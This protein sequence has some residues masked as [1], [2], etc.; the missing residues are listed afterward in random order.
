MSGRKSKQKGKR[1]EREVA[2]M[3]RAIFPEAKRGIQ[4]RGGGAE[5]ADVEIPAFHIEVKLQAKPNIRAA[6]RQA[7]AEAAPGKHPVAFT[8]ADRDDWVVSMR[9]EDWLELV[10]QWWAETGGRAA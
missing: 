4:S 8:R 5:I 2:T 9:G 7:V 1:G 6:L 10:G 3:L